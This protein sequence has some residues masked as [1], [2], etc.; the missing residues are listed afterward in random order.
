LSSDEVQQR[1]YDERAHGCLRPSSEPAT[2]AR[3]V[4]RKS[5]SFFQKQYR[6]KTFFLVELVLHSPK[7]RRREWELVDKQIEKRKKQWR[8]SGKKVAEVLRPLIA[9][10]CPCKKGPSGSK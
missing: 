10:L 1:R 7:K 3:H 8:C 4:L 5:A 2:A 9:W 6:S